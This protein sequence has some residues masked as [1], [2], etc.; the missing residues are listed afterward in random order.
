MQVYVKNLAEAV[1]SARE[2]ASISQRTL[3]EHIKCDERTILN[4]EAGRG[5]PHFLTIC[6]ILQ[7]LD[8]PSSEIFEPEADGISIEKRKMIHMIQSCSD[9]EAATLLPVMAPLIKTIRQSMRS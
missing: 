8:I 7:F 6:K 1:R 3:S 9:E 2:N 4:I 5:N